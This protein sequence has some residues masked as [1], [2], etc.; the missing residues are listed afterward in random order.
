L[1]KALLIAEGPAYN[2]IIN[3][4]GTGNAV[5]NNVNF[6]PWSAVKF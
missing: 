6:N 1:L 4:T 3:P 5:S 2:L